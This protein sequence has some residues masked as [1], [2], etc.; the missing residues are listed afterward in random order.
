MKK[1]KIPASAAMLVKNSERYLAEVLEA[2]SAFDEVL[3]LDNGSSDRTL[4]IAA[5]FGNV[6][7]CSH[8]FTGFGSMKNLAADMAKHPWIFSID[9][10]EVPDAALIESIRAAVEHNDPHTVYALSRLNHYNGRL[11]KACGWYPDILPRLY[12]KNYVRFNN[13]RVHESLEL[14]REI[15]VRSLKGR[16]KHYS[17]QNAEGL[18]QKMQ[19]YSTLYAEENR[20]R[21]T[22][23]VFK[24]LLHG[25]AAFV[26]N[27]FLKK[28]I[29]YGADGLIISSANAQGSYYKYV[30]LYEHNRNMSVAL[31]VTTYNRPDALALVLK[32]A[33][34]QTRLP[35]EIIIADDGSDRRTTEVVGKFAQ[36]SPPVAVKHIW[37]KDEGFRAAQSRNRAI[38]AAASDY[39]II[40]DGDM[41][42][43]PSFIADHIAVARKGRL[44]QGTRV[45]VSRKRTEEILGVRNLPLPDLSFGA[46]GIKKRLSALR[47]TKLAKLLAK[48]GSQKH[49]GIKSCN[50]AFFR[51]DALA[52]NGFNNDFV[53]WG[54]ED[55]EFAARCYHSGMKRHNLKFAGVA[56]H[57]WHNEA[58]RAALPKNDALLKATLAEKKTRCERGVDEF[59]ENGN[60]SENG[61]P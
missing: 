3:L 16:L 25:G 53:G 37:Q 40:I 36:A 30:K 58:E 54:R 29:F 7:V 2:L 50:M 34:A 32:S 56:Y 27:Y 21:K 11:I 59:L 15:H 55:S 41:V 35:Q 48:R 13:R 45:L 12:H 51:D 4:E 39:L 33:L 20:Y 10:D 60:M 18:I 8:E 5:Q 47:L 19:Q 24:A 38:A 42:L 44:I 52:V 57:L 46:G 43:D 23:S 31:I 28:G 17:F 6:R 1:Q 9:S 49:K 61:S 14:S 22:A 26:K